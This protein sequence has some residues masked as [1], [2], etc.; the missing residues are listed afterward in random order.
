[1]IQF[2]RDLHSLY[3]AEIASVLVSI[4]S[5][6]I[7]LIW[8]DNFKSAA[9]A[10]GIAVVVAALFIPTTEALVAAISASCAVAISIV[11]ALA[12]ASIETGVIL[13]AAPIPTPTP[14]PAAIITVAVIISLMFAF[15]GVYSTTRRADE[16]DIPKKNATISVL[17]EVAV[18][19]ASFYA[20]SHI[21]S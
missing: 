10:S 12:A 5:Y 11:I 21:S 7:I 18:I 19:L 14:S 15:I 6:G 20:I 3:K 16:M 9:Y 1:M 4:I 8:M 17:I 13:A 2:F